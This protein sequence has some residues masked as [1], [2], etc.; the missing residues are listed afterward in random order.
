M[1]ILQIL[2]ILL[3]QMIFFKSVFA[4]ENSKLTLMNKGQ[5]SAFQQSIDRALEVLDQTPLSQQSRVQIHNEIVQ[6][7]TKTQ[8]TQVMSHEIADVQFR[9]FQGSAKIEIGSTSTAQVQGQAYQL[10]SLNHYPREI[11][12]IS[13]LIE[14]EF[15]NNDQLRQLILENLERQS[16]EILTA[17]KLA[18]EYIARRD[19]LTAVQKNALVKYFLHD[20]RRQEANLISLLQMTKDP[21]K[22]QV[23]M[24]K[25]F[26]LS[27]LEAP[28]N[29]TVKPK[30]SIVKTA[31]GALPMMIVTTAAVMVAQN[32]LVGQNQVHSRKTRP[33]RAYR[34][35]NQTIVQESAK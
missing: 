4:N 6:Q 30:I 27:R 31:K 35:I 12:I 20:F 13:R 29:E 33:V 14:N 24:S 11:Q 22:K 2:I 5:V 16:E 26:M 23:L 10:N 21:T 34:S 28:V 9:S 18:I 1:F 19:R 32:S 17:E 3:T 8:Q 25:F 15:K 7:K